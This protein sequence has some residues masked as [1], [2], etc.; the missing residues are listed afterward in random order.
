MRQDHY[1][2]QQGSYTENPYTEN[3]NNFDYHASKFGSD[4]PPPPPGLGLKEDVVAQL[5]KDKTWMCMKCFVSVGGR[6]C[7]GC[8]GEEL[9]LMGTVEGLIQGFD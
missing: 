2:H 7:T 3:R 1:S 9:D 8:G 6:F 4:L 5:E